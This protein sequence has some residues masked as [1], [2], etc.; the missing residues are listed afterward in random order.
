MVGSFCERHRER[1]RIALYARKRTNTDSGIGNYTLHLAR[2]LLKA[3][4]AVY[5]ELG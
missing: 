4:L 5:R 1:M 3:T 2:A